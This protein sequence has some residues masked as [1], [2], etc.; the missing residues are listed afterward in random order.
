M[1]DY[2]QVTTATETRDQA[3]A[4]AKA[5]TEKKLAASAQIAGPIATTFWHLGEFGQAEEWSIAFRT[6]QRRYEDLESYLVENHPWD[7][8][9]IA[10][11]PLVSGSAGYL[12]WI[13]ATTSS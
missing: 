12:G 4:L 13:A 8:P 7:N 9:E 10:A 5:V 2:V 11:I 3:I 1:A 6:T